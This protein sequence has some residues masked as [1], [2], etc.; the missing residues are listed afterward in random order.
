M[1]RWC[2][3]D[4]ALA[5]PHTK[6]YVSEVPPE[7][8]PEPRR[9]DATREALLVAALALFAEQGLSGPSLD[10]ICKRAG[11]TRGAF[12]VHFESREALIV[13][14]VERVMGGFIDAIIAGGD[15]GVDLST[16]VQT[17]ALAVTTGGFPYSGKVRP[18]QIL[19][20]CSRSP[21]LHAKYTELIDDARQRLVAVVERGQAS[22]RVRADLDPEPVAQ[23]LLALVLGVEIAT[24]LAIPYDAM[25]VSRNVLR[26]LEP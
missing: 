7:T 25:A 22:G 16:I 10:A 26:M 20:A 12:Y 21:V 8:E 11:F 17:F 9:G 3:Q 5:S 24:D 23:L 18:H 1:V 2:A 6:P 19:E 4:G 15:A 14:V 13:A